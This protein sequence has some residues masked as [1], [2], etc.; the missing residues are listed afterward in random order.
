M[1]SEAGR[2]TKLVDLAGRP[3]EI[4]AKNDQAIRTLA[5]RQDGGTILA[6]TIDPAG[7][8]EGGGGAS[9]TTLGTVT[10]THSGPPQPIRPAS[11]G[12]P[13]WFAL[14]IKRSKGRQDVGGSPPSP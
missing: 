3:R 13:G 9:R 2:G 11:T 6:G 10:D 14:G 5:R 8:F 7:F 1:F 12:E 4:V